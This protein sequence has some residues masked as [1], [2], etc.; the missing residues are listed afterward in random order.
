MVQKLTEAGV[1]RIVV[2]R[3]APV[4]R[5][6]G[7]RRAAR[8]ARPAR[9]GGPRSGGPEPADLAPRG[10]AGDPTSTSSPSLVA[11]CRRPWPSSAAS[12]RASTTGRGGGPEGGWDDP[13]LTRFG[14]GGRPRPHGAAGR[15]GG[16]G[17][18]PRLLCGLRSS[19]VR[20]LAITTLSEQDYT[21]RQGRPGE[22]VGLRHGC[23]G[24]T[25]PARSARAES[26]GE[27]EGSS[28][29]EMSVMDKSLEC[30]PKRT[31]RKSPHGRHTPERWG[32][33]CGRCASRC[34]SRSRPSRPCRTRSSRRRCWAPTSGASAPSRC[35]A[36]APGQALRR[37]GR[38]APPAG[39]R[40]HPL[41]P[42]R[43]R[44]RQRRSPGSRPGA[45]LRPWDGHDKVTIDLTKLTR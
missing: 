35:R 37:P 36:A 17:R 4:R 16:A 30:W 34:G 2:L 13:E 11:R 22:Q 5:P 14:R 21:E 3:I 41:G 43:R 38:P 18:W 9:P 19:L 1:D 27:I 44:Q 24:G 33:G 26:R 23:R 6:L 15:D 25:G 32:R 28:E 42:Q 31:S 40:R 10:R 20:P 29:V 39:R 45:Q 12:P 8:A 7:G